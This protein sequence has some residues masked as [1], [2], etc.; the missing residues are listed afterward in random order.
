MSRRAGER[1][2]E[3]ATPH[4]GPLRL[5]SYAASANCLKA[6]VML[7]ILDVPFELRE[8]DIFAGET[9]TERYARINPLRETPALE[10]PDGGVITQSNAILSYLAEGTPWAGTTRADRA[11]VCAWYFFEQEYVVPGIGGVRFRLLT[12]RATRAELA[13]RIAHGRTALDL[14]NDHLDQHEWLVGEAPTTAD[15]SLVAYTAVAPDAGFDLGRWPAVAA[16]VSRVRALDR[17]EDDLVP[18]PPNARPGA[19]RSTYD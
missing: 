17:F 13:D 7:R 4:P 8:V 19:G 3:E 15:I 12:D 1:S 9:L 18:Y 2:P 6:R 16:W 14:M 10:L 5:Y 11:R